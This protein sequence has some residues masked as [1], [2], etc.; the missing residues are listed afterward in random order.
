MK[1]ETKLHMLF[2]FT[3]AYLFLFSLYA[4][5]ND[6]FEF[7]YYSVV[8]SGLLFGLVSYSKKVFYPLEIVAGLVIFG[9]LHILGGNLIVDG[10]RLYDYW[11]VDGLFKFDNLMHALGSFLVG[12]VAYSFIS[13]YIKEI[14]PELGWSTLV[15]IVMGVGA[16]NEV[17]ELLAVVFLGAADEVG[18][19]FN[20]AVDLVFNL[21]G[22][23]LSAV[24]I[25]LY[26]K[27]KS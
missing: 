1:Y 12:I 10:V 20:N 27:K 21:I 7:L 16:I 25:H 2:F 19:Y 17:L 15:L 11:F 5:L 22:G 6:N 26:R 4:V 14:P 8:L 3:L 13:P 24:S 9:L 23:S 18:G